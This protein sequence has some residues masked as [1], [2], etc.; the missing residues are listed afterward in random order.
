MFDVNRVAQ[1]TPHRSPP[2]FPQ[3][4]LSPATLAI[5]SRSDVILLSSH[6]NSPEP[7]TD[8]DT[9]TLPSDVDNDVRPPPSKKIKTSS[10]APGS[11][12]VSAAAPGTRPKATKASRLRSRSPTPPPQRPQQL[13]T[14]RLDIKLG[15]PDNYEVVIATLAKTSGQ[16]PPT[17]PPPK[18]ESSDSDGEETDRAKSKKKVLVDAVSSSF[19]ADPSTL[20]EETCRLGILRRY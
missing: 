18:P 4:L 6:D 12:P 16:R 10:S 5:N 1:R 19:N 13:K 8:N 11:K 2:E 20:T 15:G 7:I 14:I 17:P 9:R 3:L